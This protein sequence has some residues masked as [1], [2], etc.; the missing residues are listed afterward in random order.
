MYFKETDKSNHSY[1]NL[2]GG[3]GI[4]KAHKFFSECSKSKCHFH[5]WELSPG[6]SEGVHVHDKESDYEEIYYVI[7]GKGM[8]N[9]EDEVV[10]IEKGDAI[11]VPPGVKHGILNNGKKPLRFILLFEKV[12]NE[13]Q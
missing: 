11:L 5:L 4:V 2:Y 8:M 6:H 1:K 10:I 9:I 13:F 12:L 7:E 3:N